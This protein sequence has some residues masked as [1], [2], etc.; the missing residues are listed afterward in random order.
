MPRQREQI[1]CRMPWIPIA[2]FIFVI[3]LYIFILDGL[4][5]IIEN[6]AEFKELYK[7]WVHLVLSIFGLSII[8]CCPDFINIFNCD[9]HNS[10]YVIYSQIYTIPPDE[11][12]LIT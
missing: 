7:A 5:V 4:P 3:W 10:N 6:K 2:S 12:S 8:I 9:S 1:I 11:E